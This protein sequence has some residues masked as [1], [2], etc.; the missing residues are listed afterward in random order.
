M[1]HSTLLYST[2]RCVRYL[3]VGLRGTSP[4]AR[5]GAVDAVAVVVVALSAEGRLLAVLV[6]LAGRRRQRAAVVVVAVLVVVVMVVVAVAFAGEEPRREES[7]CRLRV[8]LAA[9]AVTVAVAV[10]LGVA[11]VTA[12]PV[13][14]RRRRRRQPLVARRP[15]PRLDGHHLAADQRRQHGFQAR[16]LRPRTGPGAAPG[17]EV[18]GR[19]RLVGDVAV[20]RHGYVVVAPRRFRRRRPPP[21]I[22]TGVLYHD[23]ARVDGSLQT[24]QGLAST[25]DRPPPRVP[26]PAARLPHRHSL[27]EKYKYDTPPSRATVQ[28]DG[29]INRLFK[30]Y[31]RSE[32][33]KRFDC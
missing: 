13:R 16:Q 6:L 12:P 33:S 17:G 32:K 11:A 2:V 7:H 27:T 21:P 20:V 26:A 24:T 25:R 29:R 5:G 15:R 10:A 30:I 19:H 1:L 14:G 9:V 4:A 28:E 8:P 18:L 3:R 22:V 23:A 31:R